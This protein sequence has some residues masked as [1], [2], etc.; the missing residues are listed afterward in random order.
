MSGAV[1]PFL[2]YLRGEHIESF[3]LPSSV[4]LGLETEDLASSTHELS[5]Q[6]T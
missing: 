6:H 4:V 3:N 2:T 5:K 1:P